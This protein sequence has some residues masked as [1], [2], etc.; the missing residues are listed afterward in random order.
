[1]GALTAAALLLPPFQSHASPNATLEA[2]SGISNGLVEQIAATTREGPAREVRP[3]HGFFA[4]A[5]G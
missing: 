5:H 2:A 3:M 4:E 1:M